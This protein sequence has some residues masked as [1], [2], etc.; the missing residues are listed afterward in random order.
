MFP[1]KPLRRLYGHTLVRNWNAFALKTMKIQSAWGSQPQYNTHDSFVFCTAA[2]IRF[3][4]TTTQKTI[5]AKRSVIY[6]LGIV[7]GRVGDHHLS[8]HGYKRKYVDPGCIS[9]IY[10]PNGWK[11]GTRN[12]PRS[13]G[14]NPE[15]WERSGTTQN[16]ELAMSEIESEIKRPWLLR[17]LLRKMNSGG[18]K[19]KSGMSASESIGYVRYAMAM[20]SLTLCLRFKSDPCTRIRQTC[21][22]LTTTDVIDI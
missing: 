1:V 9:Y 18:S 17:G 7:S 8:T 19:M 5:P 6:R 21:S 11:T 10:I 16:R 20:S 15:W 2:E 12:S 22:K 4:M 3:V 13:H 14:L